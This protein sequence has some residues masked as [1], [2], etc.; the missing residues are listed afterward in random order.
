VA[1]FVEAE[2][3]YQ[4]G[5]PPQ[6]T[7]IF[8]HALIRD[9]A[10]E[11]L[12]RS[13]RQQYHQRIA[14]AL[15]ERFPETAK[16]QPELLAHHYTEA[17][18][19]EQAIE[20]WQQA[21][22]RAVA[23]S[24]NLEAIGHYTRGLEILKTLPDAPARAQQELSFQLALGAPHLA[25][26]GYGAPEVER[27]YSRARELCQQIG[28]TLEILRALWGLRTMHYLRAELR[29]ALEL[30]KQLLRLAQR[31]QDTSQL[32]EA[33]RTLGNTLFNIGDLSLAR[34]HFAQALAFYDP[35]QHRSHIFLYRQ[36]SRGAA[37]PMMLGPY[38]SLAIRSKPS[39]GPTK[40]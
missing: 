20:Y 15:A 31:Q 9:A 1:Q 40:H 37:S 4:R 19:S 11:S 6:A 29:T 22:Q 8:Q 12:L 5:I 18:L 26:K 25:V 34:T 21:G 24:A 28:E 14:Q 32:V 2:L 23:R 35:T 3:L 17:G 39:R 10:Y 27:V 33:H 16:T 7:Y 13:T 38:G 36:D 30:G